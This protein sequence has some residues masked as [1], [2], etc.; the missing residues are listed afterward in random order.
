MTNPHSTARSVYD[1]PEL[2]E[3]AGSMEGVPD[4]TGPGETWAERQS[5]SPWQARGNELFALIGALLP[6]V[7]ICVVLAGA[8]ELLSAFVGERLLGLAKSPLSPILCAIVVG[9]AIRNAIGLPR[10]YEPGLQ[11]ALRRLLRLGVVLLG[12]RMSLATVGELGLVALPIVAACIAAAW[13]AMR[14]I[15]RALGLPPRLGTLIAVGTAICGNTAIVATGP[16]IGAEDDEVSYAVGTI[17]LFGVIA[18]LAYPFAAHALFAGDARLAGVFLGTAIHDTAQV[19]GAGLLYAQH[20]TAPGA[21]D[22]ATVT[23]LVRNVAMVAVIPLAA[24]AHRAESG[25]RHGKRPPFSQIVPLFVFGFV[26]MA[27]LRTLGDLGARPFGGLLSP[28]SWSETIGA[29]SSLSSWCLTIAMASVGLG[30][31]LTRLRALGA[32][33]LVAGLGAALT[34]GAVSFGMLQMLAGWIG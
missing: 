14:G 16:A 25:A 1:Q 9:L 20:F 10:V 23:K 7:A 11:F 27:L 24:L 2:W 31:N 12:I 28:E 8:G 34:V 22:A 4:W 32:R 19:A 6:G 26:A 3:W 30:T 33:P 13:L 21:L 15:A 18:L 5:R 29:L 17:T